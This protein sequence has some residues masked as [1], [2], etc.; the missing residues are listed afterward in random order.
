MSDKGLILDFII[1]PKMTL[2]E[3]GLLPGLPGSLVCGEKPFLDRVKG[4]AQEL[5]GSP[6]PIET[7]SQ[8]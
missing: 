4:R 7:N 8:G 6:C 2:K 5:H 3:A 1:D